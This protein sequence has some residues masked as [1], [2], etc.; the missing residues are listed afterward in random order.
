M[1]D[2]EC[3]N[4]CTIPP[5]FP[6]R[7]GE[8]P[9]TLHG[10]GCFCCSPN[11]RV[12]VDNR[13]GLP[14]F[15]YR[16]GNYGAIREW[17][18]DRINQT[19]ELLTWTHRAPDDPA[20]ALLEG[21]AILGDIL[22]FYQDTYANEAYLSTARWR[23]NIAEL[24]RLLGYRLSP[25]LGGNATFAFELKKDEPV[26]IPAGFPLKATM[27]TTGKPADFETRE[28]ITAYPWLSRFNLFRPLETPEIKAKTTE[29]YISA[30]EQLI[31]P[32]ELKAGEKL[33]IGESDKD[34]TAQPSQLTNAEIVTIESVRE[35]H[36]QKIFKIKGALKR[37]TPVESLVAYR[38]GRTFHHFGSNN[39]EGTGGGGSSTTAPTS[40]TMIDPSQPITSTAQVDGNKTTT[41]S[42]IPTMFVPL[43]KSLTEVLT[44]TS[45]SQYMT[46][47]EIPLDIEVPDLVPNTPM[48]FEFGVLNSYRETY[49]PHV[50][51]VRTI[52]D[53]RSTSMTW[54]VESGTVSIITI[55][56][57]LNSS[58]RD[59]YDDS[60]ELL[61]WMFIAD[62]LFH[63][64]SSPAFRIRR[65]K[66]NV[67]ASK[68]SALAFY[69]TAAQARS[70]KGRRLMFEK[71]GSGP[72]EYNVANV[73]V[74][75]LEGMEGFNQL[76]PVTLS[77]KVS[78]WDFPN[79]NPFVTVYGNL[80]DADEGKT[81]PE[82]VLG[83]GDSTLVFQNFKLPKAPL[84]YHI[85]PE[86]TPPGTP[87]LEIYVDGR[88]WHAVDTFFGREADEHVYIVR[89]D[90]DGNSWVQFGDGKTGARLSTGVKNVTARYRTGTGSHGP[91][92]TDTKVQAGAKL[93]NLDKVQ[94]PADASGGSPPEDGNNA[95][96]A[97]PGK[98]QSLGRIVSLRDFEF[99]AAAVPGVALASAAWGLVDNIPS[100]VITVLMETGRAS[101]VD[102]VRDTLNS[103]NLARGAGRY[104]VVVI[105]GKRRYVT[106][107]VQYG[108]NAEFRAD[109]VEPEIRRALGVNYGLSALE[110]D[111]TGLFSLRK[112]R[113]GGREY[114]SS[115]EGFV[116]N[117]EGVVWAKAAAFQAFPAESDDPSTL[118]LPLTTKLEPIVACDTAHILSLYDKHLVLTSSA[119]GK[120]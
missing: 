5:A 26:T 3:K 76:Y 42:T 22:T 43:V 97:A 40:A 38:L 86:N 117:V 83:S 106:A 79:E 9:P 63:E 1:S 58:I 105:G 108:L 100:I 21:A 19:P 110:E 111:Q 103:Y 36:G 10:D 35:L 72:A 44:T 65:A 61:S 54:G 14:H 118:P 60:K 78:Y 87:E 32:I 13:P 115:I 71:P 16:I 34:G 57:S 56:E 53:V 64:V 20:V 75:P 15:N 59:P 85:V 2:Q 47:L 84:T 67:A 107:S 25:A 77:D 48:V 33:I 17:L 4:G 104:P 41:T 62:A 88:L 92:K 69:G 70:L 101:E 119:G 50:T 28:E 11:E 30:P 74:N 82:E 95:R 68:G 120:S 113:F 37:K 7:P 89:E 45:V 24:V 90:T 46:H 18:F 116:Q 112:R 109:L 23:E 8:N 81:L 39:L 66:V 12:S 94:M 80:V 49:L 55:S 96:N 98:V 91:L 99:E 31:W 52:S 27:E 73:D 114:A 29:F 102:A 6:R 93:K 51:L